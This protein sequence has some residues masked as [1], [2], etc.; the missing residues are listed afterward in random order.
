MSTVTVVCSCEE[1]EKLV[2]VND[3][4]V[5]YLGIEGSGLCSGAR[6]CF[7]DISLKYPYVKTIEMSDVEF[8]VSGDKRGRRRL[9][10]VDVV[11]VFV[12]FLRGERVGQVSGLS[13][14]EIEALFVNLDNV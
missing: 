7:D 12:S 13:V 8:A 10:Q 6:I 1:T 2:H 4:V 9:N 3:K 5:V 11:P 14:A